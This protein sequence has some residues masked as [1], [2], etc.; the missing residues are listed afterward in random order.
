MK[1]EYFAF[2]EFTSEVKFFPC[3]HCNSKTYQCR[4]GV[5]SRIVLHSNIKHFPSESKRNVSIDV[6]FT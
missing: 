6:K 2:D 1:W 3:Y 5:M 4:R